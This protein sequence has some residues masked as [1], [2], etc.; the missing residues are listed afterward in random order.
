MED[1][2]TSRISGWLGLIFC[3]L[4]GSYFSLTAA[5]ALLNASDYASDL[6]RQIR[7]F[8]TPLSIGCLFFLMGFVLRPE[9]R[10]M[11]GLTAVSVLFALFVFESFMTVRVISQFQGLAAASQEGLEDK[12]TPFRRAMP[13]AYTLKALNAELGVEDASDAMLG[14]IPGTDVLL[15]T[16]HGEPVAYR[17]DRY[18]FRN[19]DEIHDHPVDL[20]VLGDSFAEGVCLPDGQDLV[21]QIRDYIPA[22]FNTGTRGAGPLFELALLRRWGPEITPP[23][24]LFFFFEGNDWQNLMGEKRKGYLLENLESPTPPGP[25]TPKPD[26]IDESARII[27]EW[28]E[29][30]FDGS[31]YSRRP[32]LRNFIALQETAGVLGLHY[33]KGFPEQPEFQEIL[34][35]ASAVAK[36]WNG[37][38]GLVFIPVVDRYIGLLPNGFAHDGLRYKVRDAAEEA[39]V[40]FIDLTDSFAATKDPRSLYG[41][42]AHLSEE[43]AALAARVVK[44]ALGK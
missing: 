19:P 12:T 15:C 5:Y 24:T 34:R 20:L 41:S 32:W 23:D 10:L 18:G 3:C 1:T 35:T 39:G 17:A 9:S 42:D 36:D 37:H 21:S 31:Y 16:L 28:W 44:D 11:V 38:V 26:Q 8:L 22:T 14:G 2:D 4:V 43:G 33:P 6:P 25:A 30:Y 13:P 27:T 7:Y 40:N 29:E